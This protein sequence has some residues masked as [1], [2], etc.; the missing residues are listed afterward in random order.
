MRKLLLALFAVAISTGI[1][2]ADEKTIT[3]SSASGTWTGDAN[4]YS[5]TID[6]FTI[7]YLKNES[8]IDCVAPQTDHIR[9]YKNAKLTIKGENNE[10]ITKVVLNV[11]ATRYA[12][13][14]TVGTGT[15]TADT[16]A[17]TITW[18]GST[19]SL[20]AVASSGQIRI[21]SVVITYTASG[22][23]SKKSADLVF[24]ETKIDIESGVDAFTA[25]TFTKATT[26]DV[27][28]VSDN[29][30]VATVSADGVIALAGGLGTAVVTATAAENDEYS[31]GTATCT[32]NVFKYNV[33]K[34]VT[35]ITSGKEYL[36]VAQ[37]TDSTMYAYPLGESKTYGNLSVGVVKELTDE[38][39]VKSLYDDAFTFTAV[40]GGYTIQDCYGRYLYQTGTY[41]SFNV[42]TDN[43][44]AWTIEAQDG[45][46]FK[47]SMNGYFFQW[48]NG[49]YK[50]WCVYT[51]LQDIAVLPM[52][53]EYQEENSGIS[54]AATVKTLNANAPVYN[55]AGQRVSLNTKGI[56]IQNGRKFINK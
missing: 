1:A 26:A 48:G 32:I 28:F 19:T 56:L 37:R 21:S 18:E 16:N 14:M 24:S 27:T 15:V 50:T 29:E 55:L 2:F 33:Y 34:K 43:A 4:G 22:G 23:V 47:I 46:T 42:S 40:D 3:T 12:L 49:T 31:A 17:K 30:S 10:E 36:I 39:K 44:A 51:E 20:E 53:Y 38:I 45:G 41:K 8:T 13:S 9:V 25:P 6:G 35:E 52:L 7:S 5:T 54:T 11:T